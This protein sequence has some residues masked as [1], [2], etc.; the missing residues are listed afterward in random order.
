MLASLDPSGN[1][2][3]IAALKEVIK[4]YEREHEHSSKH[5]V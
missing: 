5:S 2:K 3:R 1:A 4:I